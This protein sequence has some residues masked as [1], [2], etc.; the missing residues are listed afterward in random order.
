ML[1]GQIPVTTQP[2]DRFELEHIDRTGNQLRIAF[3]QNTTNTDFSA[4][5]NQGGVF[6]DESAELLLLST[7]RMYGASIKKRL[8][9]NERKKLLSDSQSEIA[10]PSGQFLG[11]ILL[12]QVQIGRLLRTLR[13]EV[14]LPDDL[15][16]D[17]LIHI[18]QARAAMHA[19]LNWRK[20]RSQLRSTRQDFDKQKES[21]DLAAHELSIATRL[22]LCTRE[23]AL[24]YEVG[25]HQYT[26][27]MR[28]AAS[29]L[30]DVYRSHRSQFAGLH[31]Q[32]LRDRCLADVGDI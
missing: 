17:P 2:D 12:S 30:E 16:F 22:P 21:L 29:E 18:A 31:C 23:E 3:R 9:D 14:E 26:T 27:L 24:M 8:T 25:S 19:S 7:L 5:T 20:R 11:T 32:L 13:P 15:Q 10:Q 4:V 1:V 6:R 28:Q